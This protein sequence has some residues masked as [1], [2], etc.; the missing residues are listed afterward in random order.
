MKKYLILL[1]MCSILFS[2]PYW[3]IED[4][5]RAEGVY[6]GPA[7]WQSEVD[8]L[9]GDWQSWSYIHELMQTSTFVAAFQVAD[10]LDPEFGGIIEGE[11][12]LDIVQTDNTQEAI[13]VWCRY[14]EITGDTAY[15][16][17]I[18]RAWIYVMNYPAYNEEGDTDY[19]RVWNCGLGL[20]A[21]GKYRQVF[22]DSTYLWYSDTCARYIQAHP[23]DF[24]YP[25]PPYDRL[26]PKVTAMA[27]GMLYQ[28]GKEV[29]NQSFQDTALVYGDRVK[30]WIEVDPS[31]R[32]NDEAWAMSGG[33]CVWGMCR[34]IFDADTAAGITWLNTYLPLMKYYQPT[35]QW[36]NSWNIWYANAYNHA[37]RILNSGTY[38]EY[39]HALTDSM[40][41]Q[42]YD[43]DGGVPPTRGWDENRDHTWVSTYM[44]FMGFEGLMDSLKDNDAGVNATIITGVHEYFLAGDTLSVSIQAVNYGF[45]A[46]NNVYYAI[47]GQYFADTVLDLPV[48]EERIIVFPDVWVP[49]DTGYFSLD[50]FSDLPGDERSENDTL[51]A[52]VFIRPLRILSG[53]VYD[54]TSGGIDT[55]LYFQF[56]DDSGSAFFDSTSTDPGTGAFSINLIDS[57]YR[58]FLY[59]EIPYPD[60]VDGYIYVTPDSVS[61]L[62][63]YIE[64]A[65]LLIMNRD[66]QAQYV[67]YFEKPLDTLGVTYK[68]WAPTLQGLFPMTRINEFRNSVIIWYSGDAVTNTVTTEEQDSLMNFLVDGGKLLLT[69]QNIGE[70]ISGST[71]FT[72]YLHAQLMSD[73]IAEVYCYPDTNDQ[74]GQT[75]LK[76]FTTGT[77]GAANQYSR[78]GIASDGISH[79]F[80]FYD[81]DLTQC[82]GLWYNDVN[83]NY[84]IVYC[85]FGLE[86][87]HKRPSHMSR[88]EFIAAV[89][90]WFGI[91]S[92]EEYII[93]G[94]VDVLR[95]FPNPVRNSLSILFSGAKQQG[96]IMI[97]VYDATGR[98]VKQCTLP[99]LSEQY[100]W[101]L[102]DERDRRVSAGV[103]FIKAE[104]DGA[105]QI[106][107]TVIVR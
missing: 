82:S 92:V 38:V 10:T 61:D 24:G 32:I 18:R 12:E 91:L 80:Y 13:W 87:I 101:N 44:V 64:P 66:D 76:V 85:A 23:L 1:V 104:N 34:T 56:I 40:L 88:T 42:D 54:P 14:Y 93:P 62:D 17:N 102:R 4:F 51:T 105:E 7:V 81:T 74:F 78:D 96:P 5:Q 98:I 6:K 43:D 53:L 89:F 103:Y 94:V 84:Q 20:F 67:H 3:T 77:Q 49:A 52:I 41:V 55:D 58:A 45:Q 99:E 68:T 29:G 70:D 25:V 72:D 69:G 95:V 60:P 46:L 33:T 16:E 35:G 19:Y 100:V 71:F 37:A 30:T 9:R 86:A 39:H 90:D 57:L 75:V 65:D 27:G 107:K 28:Y 97:T 15:F 106:V 47:D 8:Q 79:E 63:Y 83:Y 50:A 22:G 59:T 48:G 2:T 26:H 36:C 31:N 73:S 11:D 21:E